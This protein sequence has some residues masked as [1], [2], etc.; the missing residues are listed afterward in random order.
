MPLEAFLKKHGNSHAREK[1]VNY[2]FFY[3]VSLVAAKTGYELQIYQP[4]TDHEGVDVIFD[5]HRK[6]QKLQLKTVLQ[7]ATTKSWIIH[8]RLLKP[9]MAN[10]SSFG[11]QNGGA[12]GL[13]GG[14][15]LIEL[16]PT[17]ESLEMHYY[18][19][20]IYTLTLQAFLSPA[21]KISRK[22]TSTL[23]ELRKNPKTIKL[24]R[25]MFLRPRT[26]T[27]LL[28]IA[29]LKSS[30]SSLGISLRKAARDLADSNWRLGNQTVAPNLLSLKEQLA[31][32]VQQ[33]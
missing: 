14:V 7:G 1:I 11:F 25:S 20:D 31:R 15:V 29:G 27:D 19:A 22:A 16:V 18:Y 17:G 28:S 8:T 33:E 3:D 10:I 2:R 5:D 9:E 26:T 12:R 21:Q 30:N 24:T 23:K 32:L 6:M 13:E 4:D